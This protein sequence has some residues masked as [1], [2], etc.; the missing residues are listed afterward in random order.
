MR[1]ADKLSPTQYLILYTLMEAETEA[2]MWGKEFQ[3]LTDTEIRRYIN[4]M[5]P[6]RKL[7]IL[8]NYYNIPFHEVDKVDGDR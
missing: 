3:G 6:K 1:S 8:C 5:D 7:E 4:S 2:E